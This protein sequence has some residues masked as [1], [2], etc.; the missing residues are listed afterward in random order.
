M[1]KTFVMVK[2]DGVERGLV[3]KI[4]AR[5]E[6]KGFTLV[7]AKL[8]RLD[9][10]LAETHYEHLNTKPFFG[11]LVDFITSGPVFAMVLEGKDA[12]QNARSLIGATNPTEATPGTIRGDYAIDVSSNIVHG[13]DSDENAER[14]INLYF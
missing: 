11:E 13:S 5:F 8:T 10:K 9:R 6:E 4:V 1:S 3:G 2:P 7:D 12:V 14:E